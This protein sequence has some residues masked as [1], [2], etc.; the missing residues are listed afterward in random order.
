MKPSPV[1]SSTTAAALSTAKRRRK[2]RC[3]G[4]FSSQTATFVLASVA[5]FAHLR[6]FLWLGQISVSLHQHQNFLHSGHHH[7]AHAHAHAHAHDGSIQAL[8]SAS[9]LTSTDPELEWLWLDWDSSQL[10][11]ASTRK[12]VLPLQSFGGASIG[13][14][15]FPPQQSAQA[16]YQASKSLRPGSP[17]SWRALK[18]NIVPAHSRLTS[19]DITTADSSERRRWSAIRWLVRFA[20]VYFAVGAAC[21]AAGIAGS[22]RSNLFMTRLFLAHSFLD[23]LL[24]TLSFTAFLLLFTSP[25]LRSAICE[26]FASG[27]KLEDWWLA[28]ANANANGNMWLKST[29]SNGRAADAVVAA[30]ATA[31]AA[32]TRYTRQ[33]QEL[34]MQ[35]QHEQM[36]HAAAVQNQLALD[37]S[38]LSTDSEASTSSTTAVPTPSS[39]DT[40]VEQT[41]VFFGPD[42]N[43]DEALIQV[44]FP[45]CLCI[46]LAYTALRIHFLYCINRFVTK[47]WKKECAQ[48]GLPVGLAQHGGSLLPLVFSEKASKMGRRGTGFGGRAAAWSTNDKSWLGWASGARRRGAGGAGA[49][50]Q[51]Y[52]HEKAGSRRMDYL[53]VPL[54]SPSDSESDSGLISTSLL[55]ASSS[56]S[57]SSSSASTPRSASPLS[58]VSE[59]SSA[60]SDDS[61]YGPRSSIAFSLI[62]AAAASAASRLALLMERQHQHHRAGRML[63]DLEEAEPMLGGMDVMTIRG[64]PSKPSISMQAKRD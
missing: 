52:A 61:S 14:D 31:M 28:N 54:S 38:K 13:T 11:Q 2:R 45:F 42:S 19:P 51:H 26:G 48:R 60:S 20:R 63:A 35:R 18:F 53:T 36:L 62:R 23:L 32:A 39:F 43:C 1:S 47:L 25:T 5:L 41:R 29:S 64:P 37:A 56:A 10:D 58:V 6:A 46:I 50:Q 15:P 59:G 17:R 12:Q 22:I 55:A 3:L 34:M 57:S 27:A 21:A 7:H 40:F 30:S 16:P 4:L 33:Q 44:A 8:T 24:T 49:L 9:T